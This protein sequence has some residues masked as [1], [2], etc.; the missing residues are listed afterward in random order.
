MGVVAA[1]DGGSDHRPCGVS[2]GHPSMR[3]AWFGCTSSSWDAVGSVPDWASAWPKPGIPSPSSTGMPRR[4]GDC[5]RTG[6]APPSWARGSI[7]V[8]SIG[9]GG[10]GDLTGRG[11]QRRQF[12]HP[13]R[14]HRPRDLR[15]TQCGGPDLR[16][17]TGTDLSPL[18]HPHR[19]HRVVD[20]RPG[21][22]A[23]APRAR[24]SPNGPTPPA[25]CR[26]SSGRFPSGGRASGWPTCPSPE[27]SPWWRSPGP[28]SPA[29]TSTIWSAR[30]ATWCT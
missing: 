2:C 14:P 28:V 8:T 20:H 16:P 4:S 1:R 9:P 23:A 13:H 17:P 29:S 6:R 24:W 18:G 7:A 25:R 22:Q 26:S 5:P 10:R 21:A 30:K 3:V 12:E 19:G 11:D 15:D 27:T